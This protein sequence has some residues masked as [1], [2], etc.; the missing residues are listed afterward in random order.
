MY[1]YFMLG[2]AAVTLLVM[3][4]MYNIDEKKLPEIQSSAK[5]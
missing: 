4:F 1:L 3:K 5:Q 2:G